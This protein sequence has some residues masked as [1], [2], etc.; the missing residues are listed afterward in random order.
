M[1]Q[2]LFIS[3]GLTLLLLS[4]KSD[5]S[6]IKSLPKKEA[7]VFKSPEKLISFVDNK[8]NGFIKSKTIGQISYYGILKPSDYLLSQ[9]K[10]EEKNTRLS[11]NDFEDLQYFDLR[12]K[13][14]DFN[15]EFIKYD[16]ENAGQ[17]QARVQYCA[18][19][20]QQ[21]IKLI[22]GSDTL[23]CVLYHYERSFDI[24]PYGH[25]TLGFENK[26][27][28][29]VNTKTLVFYDNLFNNGIIKLNFSPEIMVNEP[30]L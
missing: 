25:F 14:E 3:I 21:D 17:Y 12:I 2:I 19:N 30:I 24:V 7:M 28:D 18:F 26:K 27:S 10:L 20:M 9:K 23:S 6:E 1:K 15:R 16:L 8:A 5:D 11:K 22:D 29:V 4:C 13:V